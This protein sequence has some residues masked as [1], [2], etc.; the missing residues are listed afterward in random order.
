MLTTIDNLQVESKVWIYQADRMMTDEQQQM[1]KDELLGFLADW[2]SHHQQ[3][4]T[5]GDIFYNRFVVLLADERYVGAGGCSIDRSVH[6][7]QYLESQYN[8]SLLERTLVAY[9]LENDPSAHS[10]KTAPL[11]DL[12]LLF[13]SGEINGNTLVFNNLVTT[14][15][16]FETKWIL[17]LAQSWHKKFVNL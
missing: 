6:F 9:C 4:L 8:I 3:L 17:P 2:T 14:K 15:A 1:I 5:A 16:A 11:A 12:K 7:I 10:I 13:N